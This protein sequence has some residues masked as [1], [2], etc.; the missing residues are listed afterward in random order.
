MAPKSKYEEITEARKILELPE[1]A[2]MREVKLNY[3]RLMARWH[4]DKCKDGEERCE[5]K[6]KEIND[7]YK[8]ITAYCNNYKF[9]FV[10]KE[11]EKYVTGDEWWFKRFGNDSVWGRCDKEP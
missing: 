10:K 3:R 6:A 8:I 11:V 7:A 5:E 1:S 2:T 9:S 4:P